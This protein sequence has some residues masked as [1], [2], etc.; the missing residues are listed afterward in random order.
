[1]RYL[2]ASCALGVAAAVTRMKPPAAKDVPWFVLS[3]CA[4]FFLYIIAFNLGQ[5]TVT[6]ATGSVV[7]ATVPVIT[8]LLASLVYRERLSA[9]QWAAILIEFAGVAVLALS[10]DS[11]SVNE[12][13]LWLL[14]AALLLSA[15]NLIQ[16]KLTRTYSALQS[17]TYSIFFGTLLLAVFA[18]GSFR[19]ASRAPAPAFLYL[20]V[21]GVF[22][23]AVSYAAWSKAFA[24]ADKTSHV[25]NYMFITP[26]L[27]SILGFLIAR[28]VP[29]PS[30][31]LGGG[32]ILLGVFLF[33]FGE[34]LLSRLAGSRK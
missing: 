3:G 6:A 29:D 28:E 22:S 5:A 9:I 32:I 10:G 33:N 14:L 20:A 24:K 12:G 1:M 17:S 26:F 31:L 15:Y 7:I 18:P 25:S 4:G 11:L 8:A 21:M 27:T 2:I 23:S 30:T 16:R 19:E 13:L 34:R